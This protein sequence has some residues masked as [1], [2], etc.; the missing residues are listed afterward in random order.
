MAIPTDSR[1]LNNLAVTTLDAMLPRVIEGRFNTNPLAV[2]LKQQHAIL[3]RGGEK[4]VV[5]FTYKKIPSV[6][7]DSVDTFATGEEEFLSELVFDWKAIVTPANIDAR[8]VWKNSGTQAQFLNLMELLAKQVAMSH[9]DEIGVQIFGDGTGNAGKNWDGL[10]NGVADTGAYGGVTRNTT[11]DDPG[12]AIRS[13]V[14]SVGGP[15]SESMVNA[16]LTKVSFDNMR[17][18]LIL[19]TDAIWNAAWERAQAQDRNAPGPLRNVGFTTI[20][21]NGTE[22]VR[23]SHTPANSIFILNTSFIEMWLGEGRNFWLRGGQEGFHVHNQDFILNQLVTYGNLIVT[24]PRF[25]A[26][27]LNVT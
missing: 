1:A 15:Y 23:D 6:S 2:R 10:V 12:N 11:V 26:K 3:F 25:Q 20:N 9:N 21:F 4:I 24:G 13:F 16:A 14:N 22:M 19:V 17:P 8:K 18:D 5:P 7:F 27:I